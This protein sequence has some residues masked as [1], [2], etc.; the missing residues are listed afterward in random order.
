MGGVCVGIGMMIRGLVVG[1][2]GTMV[3]EAGWYVGDD[4]GE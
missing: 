4:D 1:C 3:S 2:V